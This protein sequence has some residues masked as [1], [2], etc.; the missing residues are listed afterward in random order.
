MKKRI[1]ISNFKIIAL[2]LFALF[3]LIAPCSV[4]NYLE[5]QLKI[6]NTQTLNR[7]KA[8]AIQSNECDVDD[9]LLQK[10]TIEIHKKDVK[11]ECTP[12]IARTNPTIL[13]FEIEKDNSFIA[14]RKNITNT[15][16]FYILYK[17]LKVM[18]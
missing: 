11:N 1:K 3:L 18:I 5:T 6:E 9:N 8:T 4:R 2:S 12:I 15:L 10:S 13:S 14:L 17:R 16:P 7:N